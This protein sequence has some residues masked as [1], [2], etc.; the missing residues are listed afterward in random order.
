[1]PAAVRPVRSIELDHCRHALRVHDGFDGS[2]IYDVEIPLHLAPAV[3]VEPCRTNEVW[4]VAGERR[5]RLKWSG[6]G[7]QMTIEAARVFPSYGVAVPS[8]RLVW[9]G[10]TAPDLSL[11]VSIESDE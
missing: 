4:L 8:Q 7:W 9:R 10:R 6:N 11:T 3:R 5:F 2:G 1:L